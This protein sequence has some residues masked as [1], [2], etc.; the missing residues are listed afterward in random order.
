[1]IEKYTI[2][3]RRIYIMKLK[4]IITEISNAQAKLLLI[5]LNKAK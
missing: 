4:Q 2:P 3:N 1:M 5:E